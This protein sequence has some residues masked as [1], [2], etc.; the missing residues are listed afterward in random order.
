MI[1]EDVMV[2]PYLNLYLV[3]ALGTLRI[4]ELQNLATYG[5]VFP[6]YYVVKGQAFKSG[7]YDSKN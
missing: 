1:F 2:V 3:L 4:L 5:L 6:L 7:Y